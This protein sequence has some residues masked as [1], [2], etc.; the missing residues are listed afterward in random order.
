[1]E[2]KG[3][4]IIYQTP[5]GQTEIDVRMEKE[6]IWLTQK[7]IAELFG[8]KRPAITKHLNN[9]Y[10]SGELEES[11]TCS[12]LEHMGNDGQQR[13]STKFYNL[14]AILSVG[15][16]VNSSNATKFRQWAN[17]VLKSYLIKGYAVNQQ[18]KEQQL[19]DLKN[20]VKLLSNVIANKELTLDEANGLLH[21]ITDYTYG[22]DTLDKYDYQQ[23]EIEAT[24][25]KT[26]FRATYDEAMAAIHLLQ[27]KFGSSDLF[28]N[29]KDQSFHSSINT[30]YQ[31]FG[32]D[33][34]Y[35]SIEEKASMLF[36]LVV[37][38]H[39]FSDGNKRIAA[40]LFLWFL[41]KNGI[42]YKEDGSRLIDNNALVALTLMIAESRTEE[43]DIMVKVVVNLINKNN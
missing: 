31:T 11:S 39:S 7:Q 10:S 2:N 20:T 8:T 35:P 24:T 1:M 23:L 29:E 14:D 3:E 5:D 28:G 37:K 43:K 4:I 16:R 42:L 32:G 25:P 22:L 6:T 15:Y 18:M 33:E 17:K 34:L 38:N 19:V 36:Y 12:I 27:K 9:I 21:V 30:I 13:Y 26:P 40:F 41:E